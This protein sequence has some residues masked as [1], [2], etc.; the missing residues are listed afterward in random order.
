MG[1]GV[2]L[3]L[4]FRA[5]FAALVLAGFTVAASVLFHNYWA[6]PADQ[7]YVQQLMF[8]KNMA[9]VGGLLMVSAL[10]AGNWAIQK[11]AGPRF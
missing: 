2:V 8:I 3:L 4:G 5:R 10:G 6:L 9:I 1:A 7:A 11:H